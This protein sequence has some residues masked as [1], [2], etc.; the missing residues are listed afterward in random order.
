MVYEG[1]LREA[2]NRSVTWVEAQ[3]EKITYAL[4]ALE[5][6]EF[7]AMQGELNI[8]HLATA[9]ALD[10]LDFRHSALDWRKGHAALDDWHSQI[11]RRT[12]LKKTLPSG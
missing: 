1:R 12:S 8:T 3:W 10:Y 5:R 4:D 9:C 2:E 6:Q 11:S 7:A